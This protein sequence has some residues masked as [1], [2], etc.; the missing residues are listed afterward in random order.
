MK[1]I[2][3]RDHKGHSMWWMMAGCILPLVL[4]LFL[5]D[6]NVRWVFL[7]VI[8]ICLITHA[9]MMFRHG[10]YRSSEEHNNSD[11]P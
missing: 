10:K 1:D 4:I 9:A 7:L 3:N 8:G 5:K 11:T 6:G 2:H